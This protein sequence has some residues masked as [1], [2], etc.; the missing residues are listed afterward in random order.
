MNKIGSWWLAKFDAQEGEEISFA[1][2]ANRTQSSGR[3]IGG[4]I[5]VTNKRFLFTP[6]L[7]DY[8]LGGKKYAINLSDI[9]DIA[10]KKAGGD[11]FGG[12]LRDRLQ[13]RHKNGKELYVVNKLDYIIQRLKSHIQHHI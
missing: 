12:G 1:I 13:I 2:P 7:L 9:K 8:L 4:K 11:V 6:H 10:R 5:F 3:A